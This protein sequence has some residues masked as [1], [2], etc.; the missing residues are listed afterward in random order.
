M[1]SQAADDNRRH[2]LAFGIPVLSHAASSTEIISDAFRER[3]FNMRFLF[4]SLTLALSTVANALPTAKYTLNVI[5]EDGL[6]IGNANARV[7][8]SMPKSGTWGSKPYGKKGLTDKDGLFV[9][10]GET[11][12]FGTY[13]ASMDGYYSTSHH[14][15]GLKSVSGVIGFRRWEPW[16]PILKVI[17][18][19]I[20]NPISMYAYKT[21]FIQFTKKNE[22]IGYDLTKRDWVVP[23][24]KGL[25][26]DFLMK[27]NSRMAANDDYTINFD[28][29]FSNELDGV[30][31]FD[32][33]TNGG[34]ELISAHEA[35][36]TGY[37]NSFANISESIPGK[38]LRSPF[39]E[40]RNYYFRI[41]C[42]DDVDSC[43]YG[44]IY[45]DIEFGSK[46]VNFDY[47]LNPTMGDRNV[48]FDPSKNLFKDISR[49]DRITRP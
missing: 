43:L 34:S 31:A 41:R 6:P 17:L 28:I 13:G 29:N 21:D 14:Y 16:N 4:L 5:N 35:P 26:A 48:E 10:E 12:Q 46:S 15:K 32:V 7:T 30:Q 24:G 3:R 38:P 22:Y 33:S 44:K 25:T 23:Y 49:S 20:K 8:F 19:A 45:G 40:G 37:V 18:K 1:A 39:K 9:A 27:M 36:P 42:Q 47:Y 11:E 2:I